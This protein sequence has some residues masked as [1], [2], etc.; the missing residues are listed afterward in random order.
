MSTSTNY[1]PLWLEKVPL[2]SRIDLPLLPLPLSALVP[3]SIITLP[4]LL[5]QK[6]RQLPVLLR[7]RGM[8]DEPEQGVR[9]E[10][11][12]NPL[13]LSFFPLF[14]G[15]LAVELLICLFFTTF[16][17]STATTIVF[18]KPIR[19]ESRSTPATLNFVLLLTDFTIKLAL[20]HGNVINF[21]N[22]LSSRHVYG[23]YTICIHLHDPVSSNIVTASSFDI[24]P[25]LIRNLVTRC[26][27]NI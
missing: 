16:P 13:D 8:R 6:P 4:P 19:I 14:V 15:N 18:Q 20:N 26:H 24:A 3:P 21:L 12:A 10:T 9:E 23:H 25:S 27:S 5:F 17:P 11:T 1:T 22:K 7:V 2:K